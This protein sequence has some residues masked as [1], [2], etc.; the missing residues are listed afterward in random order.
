MKLEPSVKTSSNIST[1][2]GV[3]AYVS[4][5]NGLQALVGGLL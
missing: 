2:L 3:V 5:R 4:D 1:T